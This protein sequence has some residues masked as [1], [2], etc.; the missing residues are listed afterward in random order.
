LLLT[1]AVI[2]GCGGSKKKSD[3]TPPEST[4]GASTEERVYGSIVTRLVGTAQAPVTTYG[5]RSSGT[6]EG[7][8]RAGIVTGVAGGLITELTYRPTGA[9]TDADALQLSVEDGDLYLSNGAGQN[10]RRVL[11]TAQEESDGALSPDGTRIA[12]SRDGDIFSVKID[13]SD[14]RQLTSGD[15]I[16][17]EP[18][19]SPDG[20]RIA[21]SRDRAG[22]ETA[23]VGIWRMASD[24]TGAVQLTNGRSSALDT[25][26][27]RTPS[28]SPDGTRIVYAG[29]LGI[30]VR[31]NHV[32]LVPAAGG[33][34]VSLYTTI[35]EIADP[36]WSPDGALIACTQSF[37][38]IDPTF[39]S[40]ATN[41]NAQLITL[42]PDP[43]TPDVRVRVSRIIYWGFNSNYFLSDTPLH[44]RWAGDSQTLFFASINVTL[45]QTPPQAP[46]YQ[47]ER[48]RFIDNTIQSIAYE[49]RR[50]FQDRQTRVRPALSL[51]AKTNPLLD[52]KAAAFLIG[53]GTVSSNNDGRGALDLTSAVI[54]ACARPDTARVQ[55]LTLENVGAAALMLQVTSPD[56]ITESKWANFDGTGVGAP[57]PPVGSAAFPTG[58]AGVLA[59]FDTATG[60]LANLLPYTATRGVGSGAPSVV[61]TGDQIVCT[62]RFLGSWDAA[63]NGNTTAAT[64]IV[65]DA[66][67]GAIREH[68]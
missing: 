58:T 46:R 30:G 64:R 43:S 11:D 15:G 27:D 47:F 68:R 45:N 31:T 44:P 39:A 53:E 7:S 26:A 50:R 12:F 35:G 57:T 16:D 3:T 66:R 54:F 48:Y 55:R 29:N 8:S 23:G 32:L 41:G 42:R 4:S 2:A 59:S 20:T 19:W 56:G 60:K 33:A 25:A 61:Q 34:P 38:P 67:T 51:I 6:Y 65:L 13:G 28:W 37:D 14:L 24:G 10:R 40:P 9:V 52:I 21:F 36:V 5:D 17:R 63:G 49:S 22:L 62:G 1:L 18:A